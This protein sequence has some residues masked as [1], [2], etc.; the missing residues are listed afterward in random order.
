MDREQ[1]QPSE[2]GRLYIGLPKSIDLGGLGNAVSAA[3]RPASQGPSLESQRL[4][5]LSSRSNSLL[6][7]SSRGAR[8]IEALRRGANS[9][10]ATA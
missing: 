7:G 9:Q 3:V 1:I 8:G 2:L 4:L 5:R 10:V 6:R